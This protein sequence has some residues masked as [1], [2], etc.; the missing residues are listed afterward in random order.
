MESQLQVI[1]KFGVLTVILQFSEIWYNVVIY[2]ENILS[3]KMLK[4]KVYLMSE[5]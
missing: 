1:E 3:T 5:S 4:F 2:S